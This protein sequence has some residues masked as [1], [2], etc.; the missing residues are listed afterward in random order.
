MIAQAVINNL[1]IGTYASGYLFTR[2][3]GFD[4][5]DTT[6][7]VKSR[8]TYHGAVIGDKYYGRRVMTIEGEILGDTPS[9]YETK[10]RA[11]EQALDIL[12]DEQ[13]ITFTCRSGLVVQADV[14]LSK[15]I[16]AGYEAGKMIRGNFRIELISAYPF[17]LGSTENVEEVTIGTG[18]G[19]AIP[20]AIPF[21]MTAGATG[22]TVIANDGNAPAFPTIRIYGAIENPT[23]TNL[24]T[25]KTLSVNYTLTA[26]TDYI[27]IDIYNRTAKDASGNNIKRYVTGDWWTLAVGNNSIKLTGSNASDGQ[28]AEIT[29]RDSY[30]GV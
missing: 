24:T 12:N 30:L 14:I 6:V 28:L 26:E 21:D 15:K 27:D 10:R 8:G 11:L 18:G 2:L 3:S 19:G 22:D 9:D 20:M 17:L 29:Y 4:F 23:L 1:T 7:E 13:T 16:E 25:G 5:P